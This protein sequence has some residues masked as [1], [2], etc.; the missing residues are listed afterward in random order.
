MDLIKASDVI[1]DNLSPRGI[2]SMGLTYEELVEVKPDLIRVSLS[3]YGHTGPDQMR[4]S[5][6][7]ILEA[8]SGMTW[9]TGYADSGPLKLGA[10]LPDPIGG[11][12][13]VFATLAALDE[14]ERTG[15][16]SHVSSNLLKAGSFRRIT[17][18]MLRV[19]CS[20]G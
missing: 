4:P 16:G 2:R 8:H 15:K 10:A 5:W 14:R 6:G 1:L 9:A 17:A 3:G 18:C 19:S 13:A 20:P 12:H 11:L 7:P